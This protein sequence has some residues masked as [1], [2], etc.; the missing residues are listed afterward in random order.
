MSRIVPRPL[1]LL[2]YCLLVVVRLPSLWDRRPGVVRRMFRL[3]VLGFVWC[4]GLE[5]R[6]L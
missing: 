3:V 2:H 1:L 5:Y 6:E 4:T